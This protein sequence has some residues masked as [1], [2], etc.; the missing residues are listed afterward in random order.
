VP[1]LFV[2]G[3][4]DNNTPPFQADEVRKHFK[5]STHLII[6]NAGHES[7]LVNA[8]VQQAIIDHLR[9]RDVSHVKITLPPLK[10]LPIPETP[11]PQI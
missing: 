8:S 1:T 6:E 2:S 5:Q 10:F 11:K 3:T 9:G 4:F 7:M